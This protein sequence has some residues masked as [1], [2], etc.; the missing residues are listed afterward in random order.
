MV[1]LSRDEV[2]GWQAVKKG[3]AT[4]GLLLEM[5]KIVAKRESVLVDSS[6]RWS[7]FAP[8]SWFHMPLSSSIPISITLSHTE[9]L[10]GLRLSLGM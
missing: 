10:T 5:P 4:V 7:T 1:D 2:L 9:L 8:P 3:L 6:G